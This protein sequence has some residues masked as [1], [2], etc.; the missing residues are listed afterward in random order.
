MS[1]V[2]KVGSFCFVVHG[3]H[4]EEERKCLV[5]VTSFIL[6]RFRTINHE[7]I[8]VV[9]KLKTG[10]ELVCPWGEFTSKK[11]DILNAKIT[12]FLPARCSEGLTQGLSY[13]R[14]HQQKAGNQQ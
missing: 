2:D 7:E 9:A 4:T 5:K 6:K 11:L 14:L 12:Q 3:G 8:A 1:Q 13:S 10:W